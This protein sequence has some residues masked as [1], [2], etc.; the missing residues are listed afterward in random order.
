[1][2][3]GEKFN[4][5][6]ES[7]ARH[8]SERHSMKWVALL[9]ALG[10]LEV[11]GVLLVAMSTDASAQSASTVG[12]RSARDDIS[13]AYTPPTVFIANKLPFDAESLQGEA[14]R[15][16]TRKRT[17]NRCARITTTCWSAA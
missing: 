5:G 9:L 15:K 16:N 17:R 4:W 14:P 2:P 8:L 13:A 7:A 1:M 3:H 10:L 12:A 11:A 6:A